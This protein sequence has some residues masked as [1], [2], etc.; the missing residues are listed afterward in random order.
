MKN[1]FTIKDLIKRFK[2]FKLGPIDLELEPGM[3]LGL[4]GPNGSGKTTLLNCLAGL[5]VPEEG[6]I[7]IMAKPSPIRKAARVVM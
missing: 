5:L 4:I 7:S 3:V 2:N 6:S 1:A